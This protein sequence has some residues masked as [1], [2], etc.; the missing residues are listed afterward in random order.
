VTIA[1][2]SSTISRDVAGD[3]AAA[4]VGI[5]LHPVLI[6][7]AMCLVVGLDRDQQ[8]LALGVIGSCKSEMNVMRLPKYPIRS[9]NVDLGAV[10]VGLDRLEHVLEHFVAHDLLT[11]VL[12][13]SNASSCQV[14]R[15]VGGQS[16]AP[17][18]AAGTGR[19][20]N[21]SSARKRK[22]LAARLIAGA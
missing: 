21:S 11:R 17:R 3:F 10:L 14:D 20:W 6:T 7:A 4:G 2:L 9:A 12:E 18:R 22:P 16:A 8:P 5:G 1:G 19:R 15:R 13:F